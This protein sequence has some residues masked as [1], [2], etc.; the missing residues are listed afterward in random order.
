[1]Y[2]IRQRQR[3]STP[4]FSRAVGA[5]QCQLYARNEG[6]R[7][8][9]VAET[10]EEAGLSDACVVEVGEENMSGQSASR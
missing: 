8:C 9:I 1:M 2:R 4:Y 6:W 7:P 5:S 3:Q 10:Q